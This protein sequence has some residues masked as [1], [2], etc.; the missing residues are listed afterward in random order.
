MFGATMWGHRASD[1]ASLEKP[2]AP[3]YVGSIDPIIPNDLET[4]K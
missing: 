4:S 2:I 3:D 1:R